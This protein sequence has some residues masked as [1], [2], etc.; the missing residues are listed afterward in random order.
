MARITWGKYKMHLYETGVDRG[1]LYVGTDPGV[2]WNG[3][4]SVAETTDGGT[5]SPYYVD[6]E[7]YSNRMSAEEFGA[8]LSAYMYPDEFMVC[9]GTYSARP[10]LLLTRQKRIPFSLSYR[11][12]IGNDL[13]SNY[14]Y[15]IHLIYNAMASP[16]SQTHKSM[17]ESNDADDFSWKLTATP[18]TI[19]GFKNTA[20]TILDS[21]FIDPGTLSAIEDILYGSDE[22]SSRMPMFSELA[23]LIDSGATLT[24]VDNGD[25]SFALHAPLVDLSM[26]DDSIFQVNWSTVVDNGDGTYTV[27]S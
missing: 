16:S 18:P 21:R 20:H 17:G 13:S 15:K 2:P 25:G 9:D 14:G 26:L 24:V 4:T 10:G 8:T 11:T 7:K 19:S 27:S 22:V 12:M 3:I 5:P 23:D 6:G 1:V